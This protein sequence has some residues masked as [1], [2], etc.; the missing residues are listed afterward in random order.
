M[1]SAARMG[2]EDVVKVVLEDKV[3]NEDKNFALIE[4]VDFHDK[5]GDY[6]QGRGYGVNSRVMRV[7]ADAGADVDEP[8]VLACSQSLAD[9]IPLFMD[10]GPST[11]AVTRAVEWLSEAVP[12]AVDSGWWDGC[13]IPLLLGESVNLE[14]DYCEE[15]GVLL[16]AMGEI[17]MYYGEF[18]DYSV[19]DLLEE[20]FDD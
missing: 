13:M 16:E 19:E 8:L 15:R 12:N 2:H 9:V 6:S 4:A 14:E 5:D 20:V 3:H 7:L 18:Q 17:P 1:V 10:Y 11:E